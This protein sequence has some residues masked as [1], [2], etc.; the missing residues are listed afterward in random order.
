[1]TGIKRKILLFLLCAVMLLSQ[2]VVT[3]SAADEEKEIT[4]RYN[5]VFVVDE[6]SSMTD[7][8]NP[9]DPDC[10]RH[11]AIRRFIALMA[12]SGN[13]VGSVSFT[14][15]IIIEQEMQYVD[16]MEAKE[17]FADVIAD[18]PQSGMT[19]IG[20]ALS[21]A[22]EILE[23]GKDE[24]LPSAIVFLSDGNTQTPKEVED[25]LELSLEQ[26][27][28]AIED[29]R[30]AGYPIHA[31]LL[32][33]NGQADGAEIA[34]ISKATGGE[35]VEITKAEDLN[36]AQMMFYRI[37]FN[38]MEEDAAEVEI[39]D[40]GYA[41]RQFEVPGIGVEELNVI[42]E[43]DI[44]SAS[45]TDPNG[46]VYEGKEL[47]AMTLKSSSFLLIK[48]ADPVGGEWTATAYGEP[49]LKIKFKPLY[50]SAFFVETSVTEKKEYKIGDKI[51]FKTVIC[52]NDG[53]VT[54][55]SKYGGYDATLYITKG[56]KTE[57]VEMKIGDDG[58]V[59][60]YKIKDEGTFY[61]SMKVNKGEF[62]A[63]DGKVYEFSVNNSVPVAP[64]E[65]PEA[66]AN[67]WPF[68]GG[69]AKLDLNGKATDPDGD[70][71]TYSVVSSVYTEE[72]Y[73]L[74]DGV[75]TVNNFS[76]KKGSFTIKAT[77]SRG[78]HCTFDVMFT[79]TNIGI[80]M[81]IALCVIAVIVV[82]V[83]IVVIKKLASQPFAGT[84]QVTKHDTE[85]YGYCPPQTQTP[86][87]GQV[88]VGSF[89]FGEM[90]LPQNCYFQA[91]GKEKCIY[92]VAKKPVYSNVTS[93][94]AKKIKIDGM[95]APVLIC[96]TAEMNKG[97]EVTFTS[98][99]NN[100]F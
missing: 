68:F 12:E 85:D 19:N 78:A 97:I 50:N 5:V 25:S 40:E 83:V 47:E 80:I 18:P 70:D 58:F 73:T 35:Y 63:E 11:D 55:T 28:Q 82:I 30:K 33:A 93:A 15:K 8:K 17:A 22:I 9:S 91:A 16:G 56:D 96:S 52:D 89:G 44:K 36:E 72:D 13:K 65:M 53:P 21:K 81:F 87:R 61:A 20:L 51:S 54:D 90:G 38:A 39:N 7:S 95:G 60:D 14:E 77:D 10:L 74:E 98:I 26:K 4:N 2:I 43:G 100:P 76:V 67:I 45:L 46:K 94:P 99:Y 48:L 29:A 88:R 34:Q 37:I 6:S 3:V 32:N 23:E 27:A 57:E 42:I 1:M 75:L 31:V 24:K 84:I 59:C 86:G 62:V 49:G 66:H 69:K 41:E 64:E 71:I 79:S 92:F